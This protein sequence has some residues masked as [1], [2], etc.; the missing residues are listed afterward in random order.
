MDVFLEHWP[1]MEWRFG[2]GTGIRV[3]LG[4]LQELVDASLGLWWGVGG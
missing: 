3:G 1:R 4:C 2:N